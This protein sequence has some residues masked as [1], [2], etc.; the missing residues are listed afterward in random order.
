[1][2][3]DTT[4]DEYKIFSCIETLTAAERDLGSRV[5]KAAQQHGIHWAILPPNAEYAQRCVDLGCRM[6]SI[7]IDTWVIQRGLRDFQRQFADVKI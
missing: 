7:G 2:P 4:R 3:Y 1:M 5:A 6:L